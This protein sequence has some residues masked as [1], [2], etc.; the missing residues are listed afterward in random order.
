M[1][2]EA[3]HLKAHAELARAAGVP[4]VFPII[5][6]E[7]LRLAP[8]PKVIDDAPVGRRF[9]DGKLIVPGV[10]GP[11]RERRKLSAVGVVVVSMVLSRRG[12]LLTDIEAEIDGVPTEDADGEAMIDIVLD[13]VEGTLKSIPPARRKDIATVE[14]AVR[15][16][17]RGAVNE[18][19]GK[20]PICKVLVHV[21]EGRAGA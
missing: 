21:L 6:G 3:R 16:A 15:R 17:V 9:R 14:E 19:W 7:I 8:E 4:D 1:H 10:E 5:D 20:K 2:G 13:A 11:V 18:V 12:E